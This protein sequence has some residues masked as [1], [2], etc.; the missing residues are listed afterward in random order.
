M[1]RGFNRHCDRWVSDPKDIAILRERVLR[2][3][4]EVH[5]LVAVEKIEPAGEQGI[6]LPGGRG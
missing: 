5:G 3:L 1:E 4:H 6:E 2:V